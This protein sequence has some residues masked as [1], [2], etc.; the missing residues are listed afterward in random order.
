MALTTPDW[1]TRHGGELREGTAGHSWFVAFDGAPQYKL[2]AAPASG[3][4][5][6]HITQTINARSVASAGTA[7]TAE[8]AVRLG[9]EDLRKALGW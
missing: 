4:Y 9:L 7:P 1:L 3:R 5:G 6:C 2:V 8:E